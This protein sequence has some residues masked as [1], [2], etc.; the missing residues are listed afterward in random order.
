MPRWRVLAL[1]APA[2]RRKAT[3]RTARRAAAP[4]IV[5]ILRSTGLDPLGP[6]GA[7]RAELRDA[8]HRSHATA[9]SASWSARAPAISL[10]VTPVQAASRVAAGARVGGRAS[11]AERH[12]AGRLS[13]RLCPAP[14][15]MTTTM[16][17]RR[18]AIERAPAVERRRDVLAAA[19]EQR[20]AAAARLRASATMTMTR[21]SCH[22]EP[23]VITGR[24]GSRRLL[25]PPPER[26]PQ[27]A[28]TAAPPKPKPREARCRGRRSKACAAAEAKAGDQASR[29]HRHPRR[30][31]SSSTNRRRQRLPRRRRKPR[32]GRPSHRRPDVSARTGH[33]R[34]ELTTVP[35]NESAPGASRGAPLCG[36]TA[37]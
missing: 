33:G 14:M 34:S 19:S 22:R 5:T 3:V 37:E 9:R 6:A 8:R 18:A 30:N 29:Q 26:F 36:G 12:A 1:S 20:R 35:K 31:R 32:L 2:R 7:A 24:S 13:R 4:R 11:T 27:R 17:R 15:S 28:A 23:N 10:S 25:P 16:R 21:T